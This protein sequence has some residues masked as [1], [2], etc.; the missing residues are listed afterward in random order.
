MYAFL[1]Q[2]F[3]GEYFC[4]QCELFGSLEAQIL[5]L[6]TRVETMRSINIMERSLDLTEQ[7]LTG[8]SIGVGEAI[9]GQIP[10]ANS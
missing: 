4:T 3:E 5:D 2:P 6:K 9:A 10:K 8:A 1:E 7:A